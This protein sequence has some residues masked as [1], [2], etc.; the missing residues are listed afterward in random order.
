MILHP[1]KTICPYSQAWVIEFNGSVQVGGW[2]YAN[3]QAVA[4]SKDECAGE[5][6]GDRKE[7]DCPHFT[8]GELQHNGIEWLVLTQTIYGRVEKLQYWS[9]HF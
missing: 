6:V 4:R 7:Y 1:F 9:V 3:I 2:I 5:K 8:D